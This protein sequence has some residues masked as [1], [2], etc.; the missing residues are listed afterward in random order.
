MKIQPVVSVVIPTHRNVASLRELL[1]SLERQSKRIEYE[2]IVVA[3]LPEPGLKKVVESYG[4]R[5]RFL[6]TG[7]LGNAIARNKGLERAR[8]RIVLFLDDDCYLPDR[9]FLQR[10]TELHALRPQAVAIGGPYGL[11][12]GAGSPDVVR[13]LA[14]SRD[15]ASARRRFDETTMLHGGNWSFKLSGRDSKPKFDERVTSTGSE[16]ELF[17]RLRAQGHALS[18]SD[19]LA[20]VRRTGTSIWKLLRGAYS[21]GVTLGRLDADRERIKHWNSTLE[22]RDVSENESIPWSWRIAVLFKLYEKAFELGRAVGKR[23]GAS[24]RLPFVVAVT[25]LWPNLSR[26]VLAKRWRETRLVFENAALLASRETP[27]DL[28]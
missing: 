26:R 23:P 22:A 25:N 9:D 8:G 10:V 17:R 24:D 5:F 13:F 1:G 2:V 11:R 16:L 6:E 14:A 4:P 28:R 19:E 7:R 27:R 15:F 18:V 20:V 3:N 21:R 12:E